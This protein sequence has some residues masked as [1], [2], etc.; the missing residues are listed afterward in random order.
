MPVDRQQFKTIGRTRLVNRRSF[1]GCGY[2][3]SRGS[4]EAAMLIR[5]AITKTIGAD[6]TPI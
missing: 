6:E 2:T 1:A 5:R 3:L 4:A